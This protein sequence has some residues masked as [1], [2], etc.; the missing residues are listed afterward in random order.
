MSYGPPAYQPHDNRIE[1]GAQFRIMCVL[2][3]MRLANNFYGIHHYKELTPGWMIGRGEVNSNC[4]LLLQEI[5]GAARCMCPQCIGGDARAISD[6][7]LAFAG[8]RQYVESCAA[9]DDFPLY[10][11]KHYSTALTYLDSALAAFTMK[12]R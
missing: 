1:R 11:T 4:D 12:G 8:F 7:E 2:T 3:F 6:A 5:F 10:H 9:H